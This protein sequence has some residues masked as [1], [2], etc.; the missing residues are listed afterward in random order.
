M[1]ASIRLGKIRD[2]PVGIHYS[3]FIVFFGFSA[4]LALGQYPTI[5][6]GWTDAQYWIV[7]VSSVLLLFL[8]VLLHEFGHA[9]TA[10]K[11][12]IPVISITLFIFGGV[13]AISQ[14]A[15]S[16]GDEFK[17]AIAG[18]IV[19]ILTGVTFGV[20]WFL[21]GDVNEQLMALFGYIAIINIILAVFNMIPGFPLDGGR[22]LRAI[23][24]KATG[25]MR[26]ATRVVATIGTLFGSLLFL[27]GILAIFQGAVVN[28]VYL[29]AIGW[30]L[31]NAATQGR[32]QV[33]Q[34]VA[35][36]DVYVV[37]LMKSNPVTVS[38]DLS[39][40]TVVDDYVLGQNVRGLPVCEN[41]YLA[42]IVTLSDIKAV[43]QEEWPTR[44]VADIMTRRQ[45]LKTVTETTE[46]NDVLRTMGMNDFHQLPV[47]R[48]D[49]LV[50]MITRT[51]L[52]RYLQFRQE[53][54]VDA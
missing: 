45:D 8:S 17:I 18:P 24:W 44:R 11:L 26:K 32:Q 16:P 6:P 51:E 1:E 52:V 15:E 19:S 53:L 12:G 42:G 28:G 14:D 20:V 9:V 33:E 2:I 47:L 23:I 13:A 21:L 10:Q 7:A 4:L 48:D 54:G 41:G 27:L 49:E 22:V 39:V 25:S 35:L 40:Q 31:Q 3:W 50:G 36:R 5:Y 34:E 30:F 38:P 29:V 43:P 37:D 46:M